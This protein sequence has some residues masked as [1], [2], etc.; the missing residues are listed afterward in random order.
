MGNQNGQNNQSYFVLP[1]P[2]INLVIAEL[3]R[4]G[5]EGQKIGL[6]LSTNMKEIPPPG[7][8]ESNLD[9]KAE[10][11]ASNDSKDA[12]PGEPIEQKSREDTTEMAG[13][14]NETAEEIKELWAAIA[15]TTRKGWKAQ[16]CLSNQMD[17]L[18]A[19]LDYLEDRA[20]INS[21]K[22]N[23]APNA[24]YAKIKGWVQ[25]IMKSSDIIALH[26]AL[27]NAKIDRLKARL[28]GYQDNAIH[29]IK[30]IGK[31]EENQEIYKERLT[32]GTEA[33]KYLKGTIE[34]AIPAIENKMARLLRQ[35][36]V[37]AIDE[38]LARWKTN[39]PPNAT[40]SLK[41]TPESVIE[42]LRKLDVIMAI[43]DKKEKPEPLFE[44]RILTTREAAE[45]IGVSRRTICRWVQEGLSHTGNSTAGYEIKES[46]L[47][48]W[49]EKGKRKVSLFKFPTVAEFPTAILVDGK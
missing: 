28:D 26:A 46:A 2:I 3:N 19:R 20:E 31:L 41:E 6:I 15:T 36:G 22:T 14:R 7:T 34:T 21:W 43:D 48:E 18:K 13:F 10:T 49:H 35:K 45:F 38:D 37:L 17:H 40:E 44:D 33:I 11:K 25:E 4:Y 1:A 39:E 23:E 8:G 5:V 16:E 12:Q 32:K 9:T 42:K 30:R 24:T 29:S 27:S 47:I